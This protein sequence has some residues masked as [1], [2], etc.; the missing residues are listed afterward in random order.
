[1]WFTAL[2]RWFDSNCPCVGGKLLFEGTGQLPIFEGQIGL[3]RS[4]CAQV[5]QVSVGEQK[6]SGRQWTDSFFVKKTM[7]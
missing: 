5:M 4:I 2:S 6:P 7:N 1:M 3:S